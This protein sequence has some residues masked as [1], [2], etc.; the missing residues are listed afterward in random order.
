MN[1]TK[2]R[3]QSN[4]IKAS[5]LSTVASVA[6]ILVATWVIDIELANTVNEN[7]EIIITW[8]I[9]VFWAIEAIRGRVVAEKKIS[10]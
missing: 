6:T 10:L 7:L 1:G 3:Y 8:V 4:T 9:A 5:I 2:K